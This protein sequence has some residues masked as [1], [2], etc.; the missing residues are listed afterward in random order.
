MAAKPLSDEFLQSIWQT[1]EQVGF[2]ITDLATRLQK[3]RGTVQHWIETCEARLGVKRGSRDPKVTQTPEEANAQAREE[4]RHK[5]EVHELRERLRHALKELNQAEDYRSSIFKI[6]S[7]PV[8]VPDWALPESRASS[9]TEIPI[10][11]ASDWQWGEVIQSDNLGGFNEFNPRVAKERVQLMVSKAIELSFQHRG[12]KK[13]PG[14]YYWRGGDLISGEI[15]EDLLE[16]NALQSTAAARDLVQIE[17]WAIRELRKAFGH[18]HVDSVPGN[19]GRTT[20]KPRSKWRVEDNFDVMTHYWLESLFQGDDK[21]CFSAPPSG[22]VVK[23]I[24]G[25]TF[26]MTHGDRIGS[27]GGMGF[28]GPAATIARGMKKAFDYYGALGVIVDYFLVGHFHV[29]LMLEY[30]FSNGSLP[31]YSEYAKQFRMRPQPP[32]QWLLYVH[33]DY[34]VV[35]H[36]ALILADRPRLAEAGERTKAAA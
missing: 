2:N 32:Q 35:D 19:H 27:S 13:Y 3:P 33:P 25:Y 16:T 7:Q 12:K 15:H 10:L 17:T 30:G 23:D 29:S 20:Q 24:Y 18:V 9:D 4:Q 22:D 1:F 28:I 21:V 14:I 5:D 8:N 26:C 6:V 36:K 34:G 11:F 31:G